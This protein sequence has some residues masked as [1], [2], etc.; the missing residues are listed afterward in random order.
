MK[1]IELKYA[2]LCFLLLYL[3]ERGFA[4]CEGNC[5]DGKGELHYTTGNVYKGFFKDSLPNGQGLLYLKSGSRFE[6]YFEQGKLK[7]G[8]YYYYNGDVYKGE[9]ENNKRHGLGRLITAEGDA[10]EGRWK[11]GKLR[12]R[13]PYGG[14]DLG[15][16]YVLAVSVNGSLQY[17]DEDAQLFQKIAEEYWKV[18]SDHIIHLA[19]SNATQKNVERAAALLFSKCFSADRIIFYFSGHGSTGGIYLQDGLF[20]SEELKSL[21]RNTLALD[22]WCI[23]DACH[24][25]SLSEQ[26]HETLYNLNGVA[27]PA[28]ETNTA[29]SKQVGAQVILFFSSRT[30][31]LTAEA[32]SLQQGLFTHA[33]HK[34]LSSQS[35]SNN[36]QMITIAEWFK[37]TQA[38]MQTMNCPHNPVMRGQ[39]SAYYPVLD[40]H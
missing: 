2:L 38:I 14:N 4:Q 30:E 31:E 34:A 27:I 12:T 32:L 5:Y 16:T 9:F 23:I 26:E 1:R 39:F 29:S 8:N 22:K 19:D 13:A 17:T 21:L 3:S 6:G 36:D 11:Q 37:A 28:E 35:D 20:T 7:E 33:L 40:L 24:A 25:E 15:K 10:F 18:P